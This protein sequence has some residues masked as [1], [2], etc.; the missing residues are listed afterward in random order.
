[1]SR[2]QIEIN[3]Q[4]FE[5]LCAIQCTLSEISS[6]LRCSDDTVERWCKR[7]Y[8]ISFAE[9]FKK[10][11]E[12]GKASLRRMQYRS[13]E[14]GNVAMQIFLGKQWLGQKDNPDEGDNT[15]VLERLAELLAAQTEAAKR[16]ANGGD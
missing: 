11:S 1:M 10:Y 16:E 5:S 2:R 4:T 9:A 7:Y 6:V 12:G 14:S 15:E 8:K 3:N 13:A